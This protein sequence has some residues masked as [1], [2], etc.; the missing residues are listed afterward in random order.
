MTK[1]QFNHLIH[2]FCPFVCLDS[3]FIS[4]STHTCFSKIGVEVIIVYFAHNSGHFSDPAL[5][6][7]DEIL[8]VNPSCFLVL[9]SLDVHSC[10]LGVLLLLLE[11]VSTIDKQ[12]LVIQLIGEA[13]SLPNIA[14]SEIASSNSDVCSRHEGLR[15]HKVALAVLCVQRGFKHLQSALY[16][17]SELQLLAILQANLG[18]LIYI[19]NLCEFQRLV[20]LQQVSA[21]VKRC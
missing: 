16:L 2:V 5:V 8:D 1:F 14:Q 13:N 18:D 4:S 12:L 11:N 15:T 3:V 6:V 20:P 10:C 9:Q 17:F 7:F 21:H 19:Q